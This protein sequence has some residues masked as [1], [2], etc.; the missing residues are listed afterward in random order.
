MQQIH[1]QKPDGAT[2]SK[3]DYTYDVLGNIKTWTQQTDANPAQVYDFEYDRAD[4]LDG[5]DA[6]EHGPRHGPE[7][8]RATTTTLRAT[9]PS[10]RSTTPPPSPRYDNMNRLTTPAAGRGARVPRDAERAGH[11]DGRTANRRP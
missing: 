2:L 3:F 5:R 7:A 1:H 6:Q 11:G 8:L 9:G 4:Q 10:S